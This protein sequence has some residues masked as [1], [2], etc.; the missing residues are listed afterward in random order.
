MASE[1]DKLKQAQDEIDKLSRRLF[2]L[3]DELRGVRSSRLIGGTIAARKL[4][5]DDAPAFVKGLPRRSIG[6]TKNFVGLFLPYEQKRNLGSKKRR[7]LTSI[8]NK[9]GFSRKFDIFSGDRRGMKRVANERYN[10]DYILSVVI[11]YYNREATIDDTLQSLTQQ[12]FINFETI[13]VDDGSTEESSKTKLKEIKEKYESL[14]LTIIKQKN[15]GVAAARNNG[16]KKAVGKY[17]I[18][19]DSDDMLAPTYIEKC[20]IVLE[21]NPEISLVTTHRQDMG[22]FD[23]IN[24]LIDYQPLGLRRDNMITTAS[25]FTKDAFNRAGGFKSNIGYEDWELWLSMAEKGDWGYTIPE[26]LFHYRVALESRYVEDKN[27]HKQNIKTIENLHKNYISNV[28]AEI[29]KRKQQPLLRYTTDTALI[30][31]LDKDKYI[32]SKD[33]KPT[34]LIAMSW[35]TFGGAET[36]VYNFC[37]ALKDHYNFIFVTGLSSKNEWEYKFSELSDKIYHLPNLFLEKDLFSIGIS[38]II[39]VH[40]VDILHVVH[41]GYVYEALPLIKEN[42]PNTK[43]ILTL[44]NDRVPDYV[45]NMKKYQ[46]YLDIITVDSEAVGKSLTKQLNKDK[47]PQV[48][49]NGIDVNKIFNPKLYERSKLRDGLDIKINEKAVFFIGRLSEEKNPD[50]FI[51]VAQRFAKSNENVKFFIVG[52]GPMYKECASLIHEYK[53][54]SIRMLGYSADVAQYLAAADIMI[55]PSS[56]EGFPLSILE[57]MSMEVAVVASSVGA[58]SDVKHGQNGMCVSPGSVGDI[59]TALSKLVSDE[60]LL[61]SM[62]KAGRMDVK[63]LYSEEVLQKNYVKLYRE[64]IK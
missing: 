44:F 60:N 29:S 36:L 12:T 42:N 26:P 37:K 3:E 39:N 49:P 61:S 63:K 54:K 22:V 21:P 15:Q 57:A 6:Y 7:L 56:I 1:E 30:N 8:R 14:N 19:L 27:L 48:I 5:R 43:T 13:L 51:K 45:N 31:I 16:I 38:H 4:V 52:D 62:K 24:K 25:A 35:M 40:N 32:K 20:L 2:I 23:N 17:I 33:N 55:L 47:N 28:K 50:V 46:S 59:N 9:T 10:Q 41:C 34:I 18:C 53:L 64:V 11:P 58:I